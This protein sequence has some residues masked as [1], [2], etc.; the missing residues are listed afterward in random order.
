M[1][2]RAVRVC[3]RVECVSVCVGGVCAMCV[4]RVCS[5]VGACVCV[6]S[7]VF[8]CVRL[9]KCVFVC[10]V[11]DSMCLCVDVLCVCV[12]ICVC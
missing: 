11:C 6:C 1:C 3:V 12:C 10:V 4:W 2:V 7:C 8:V 5:C 9:C